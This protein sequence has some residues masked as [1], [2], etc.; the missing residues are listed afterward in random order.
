MKRTFTMHVNAVL[1]VLLTSAASHAAPVVF[2]GFD[3]GASAPG[4]NSLAAQ[5]A[6]LAAAGSTTLQTFEGF[7]AGANTNG[8]VGT[9]FTLSS[10][11]FNIQSGTTCGASLCGENTTPGGSKFAY[12]NAAAAFLTF[13]FISP[14]HAFGALFGGLQTA[15]NAL[16]FTDDGGVQSIALNP[17]ANGG[18]AFVGFTDTANITSVKVDIPFDLISVDDVRFSAATVP[19][20]GTF[21]TMLLGLGGLGFSAWRRRASLRGR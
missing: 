9:G 6:F 18:F 7:A 20:P 17:Q 19:E 3:A 16:V 14:I 13:N 21:A 10:S 1:A 12:S 11:G 15:T 2:S 4:A 5:T 8:L